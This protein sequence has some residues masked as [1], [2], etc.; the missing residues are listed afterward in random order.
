VINFD[1]KAKEWDMKVSNTERA[2]NLRVEIEKI[3]PDTKDM[4]AVEYGCG[5]GLLGFG[6]LRR[7]KEM[8]F[9]D[10]SG[11]MLEV[12]DKKIAVG[13]YSN[14]KTILLDLDKPVDNSHR[15]D[16]I[17]NSML[18]HHIDDTEK[19]VGSW[20]ERLNKG[21]YLCIADLMPED[22]TFHMMEFDGHLGFD[23]ENL[24][25]IME[26]NNLVVE[27]ITTPHTERRN[28]KEYP[29]FLIVAKKGE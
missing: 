10:T 23:P 22:G 26:E 8:T 18:L 14:C 6:L 16:C 2:E 25:R 21:G 17:L 1:E 29:V 27:S 20:S 4:S 28:G 13:K 3:L 24:R 9:S 12:V 15:Y 7:F 5:T 11:G 19:A